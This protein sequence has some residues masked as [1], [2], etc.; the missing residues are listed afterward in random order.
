[1]ASSDRFVLPQKV[2]KKLFDI[3]DKQFQFT[4][5]TYN[6]VVDDSTQNMLFKRLPINQ[7]DKI[8]PNFFFKL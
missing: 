4:H 3:F 2:N 8:Y 6:L 5:T 1:M 7:P